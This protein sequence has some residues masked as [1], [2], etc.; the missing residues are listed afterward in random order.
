M[1]ALERLYAAG[2]LTVTELGA[3]HVYAMAWQRGRGGT[4]TGLWQAI[5]GA[6]GRAALPTYAHRMITRVCVEAEL[7]HSLEHRVAG[8]ASGRSARD[9]DVLR[10]MLGLVAEAERTARTG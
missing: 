6:F 9:L 1:T 8:D 7:P 4:L 2:L 10:T 3:G 5:D